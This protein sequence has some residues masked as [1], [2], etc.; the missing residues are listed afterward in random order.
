MQQTIPAEEV[1][2][3]Q[4]EH[5]LCPNCG[6]NLRYDIKRQ[7]YCCESCGSPDEIIPLHEG[8]REYPLDGYHSWEAQ[9]VA[10]EGA[11]CVFCQNC[12][13][14]ILFGQYDTATVCPMC[15]STQVDVKKQ[16]SGIP[17]E[18]I[19]PFRLDQKEAQEKFHAWIKKRWFA[20]NSLK[21]TYQEGRLTGL[22][23]P[24]WTYDAKADGWFTGRGGRTR[25]YRD[26]DGHTH[27]TTDWYPVR[28]SVGQFFNDLQVC[29]SEKS[30]SKYLNDVLPYDTVN[31]IKPY[32]PQYISG[33]QAEKYAWRG[34]ACFRLAERM[35]KDALEAQARDSIL[36]MGYDQ[37]QVLEVQFSCSNVTYKHVLLPL[38]SA[39]FSHKGKL[40]QYL[41]NGETGKVSGGRPYS[42][43]KIVAAVL[44]AIAVLAGLYFLIE[45]TGAYAAEYHPPAAQIQA[46]QVDLAE[47]GSPAEEILSRVSLSPL[48]DETKA[49]V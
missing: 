33:F 34:D 43:P 26:K 13:A 28:G 3:V 22:Y 23:I 48:W 17:P 9:N 14:Q 19:V 2:T 40:Y 41:I 27:T 6:G 38:W 20:P 30:N 37:A 29:A 46:Q 10:F 21:K 11:S 36:A 16:E 15:G 31:D 35:I 44:A 12:G 25:T 49:D 24:F 1:K 39:V 32:S 18:G 4:T 42:A 7:L 45:S 8:I 5:F 47:P